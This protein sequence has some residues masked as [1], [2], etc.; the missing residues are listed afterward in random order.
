M[1]KKRKKRSFLPLLAVAAGVYLLT[2]SRTVVVAPVKPSPDTLN[3]R[4]PAV[5]TRPD[6]RRYI[7]AT[8]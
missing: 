7:P 1:A 2:R 4:T 6:R 3:P 8:I 5:S